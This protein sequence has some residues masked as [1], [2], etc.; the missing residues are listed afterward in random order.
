TWQVL[1][2]QTFPLFRWYWGIE[3]LFG[4]EVFADLR[5]LAEYYFRAVSRVDNTLK[6]LNSRARFTVLLTIGV[7]IDVLFGLV[8]D[9]GASITAA[10]G[11][12]MGV[13]IVDGQEVDSET[14][15]FF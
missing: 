4:A 6:E 10:M 14:G 5:L 12:E 15:A 1:L 3:G 7:D 11:S 8:A 9:A 2:D 13:K